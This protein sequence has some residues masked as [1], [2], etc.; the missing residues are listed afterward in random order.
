MNTCAI[1]KEPATRGYPT[2]GGG[3]T[4]LCDACPVTQEAEDQKGEGDTS[5]D[6]GDFLRTAMESFGI[7]PDAWLDDQD[8]L[9]REWAAETPDC[10]G[11][12]RVMSNGR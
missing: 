4:H 11:V 3:F 1:C 10:G 6:F 2:M 8:R 5:E 9:D 7:D 12:A